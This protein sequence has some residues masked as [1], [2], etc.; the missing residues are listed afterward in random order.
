MT[1][2]R[3]DRTIELKLSNPVNA[4]LGKQTVHTYTIIDEPR[5][6]GDIHCAGTGSAGEQRAGRGDSAAVRCIRDVTV[7]FTLS[8]T[9]QERA[10]YTIT[11]GP[12]VIKAERQSEPSPSS[13]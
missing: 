7:P 3:G 10:D 11:P 1:T 9:A 6:H 5:A 2:D 8:G 4:V 12:L 13:R